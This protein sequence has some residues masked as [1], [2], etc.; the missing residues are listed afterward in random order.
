MLSRPRGLM[1]ASDLI[2]DWLCY[3]VFFSDIFL[4]SMLKWK[5]YCIY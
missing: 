1:C 5:D 4:I 2:F 3:F